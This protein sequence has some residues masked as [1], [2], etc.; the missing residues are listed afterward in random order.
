MRLARV[1]R[2]GGKR[3]RER[4]LL[5]TT[6]ENQLYERGPHTRASRYEAG[7]CFSTLSLQSPPRCKGK[8]S[9]IAPRMGVLFQINFLS[10]DWDPET[11]R[12]RV[13]D[14]GGPETVWALVCVA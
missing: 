2:G 9:V 8:M 13:S 11:S 1:I 7:I 12:E 5:H 10:L 3:E 14:W 6:H 4:E